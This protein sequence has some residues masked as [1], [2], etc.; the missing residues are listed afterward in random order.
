MSESPAERADYGNWVPSKFVYVPGALS[1]LFAGLAY[2]LPALAAIAVV[3]FLCFLYF[4]YARHLFSPQGGDIQTS[5]LD[6]VLDR[7]EGWDGQGRVLDIG[8]G[9]GPLAIRIAKRYPQ[10]EVVGVDTW[11]ATW[12]Y[13]Q[14]VCDRNASI[15][16]VADQV[17]FQRAR[18]SSL[19]FDDGVL[20]LVVS[21]LVFH[22][23][24]DVRDKTVLLKE[25]LRV[26]KRGG[27]FVLQDLFLWKQVY[28]DADDLLATIRGWGIE[29]VELVDTSR[30]DFIP[31]VLKLPFMLGTV[32]ILAGRK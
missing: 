10:A 5:I 19:P 21:N 30:S 28:G 6:L 4:S 26:L 13:G 23:V 25:A 3:L 20:D 31:A 12:E 14:S 29:T 15:E 17:A 16:G 1:L 9:N 2:L 8:C 27:M 32:G 11:G 22:E 24:R 7:L 18:A